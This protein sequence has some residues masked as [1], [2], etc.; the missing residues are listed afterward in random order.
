MKRII[1]AIAFVMATS[2]VLSADD[3]PVTFSQL[4][5]AAQNFINANFPGEKVSF[6]TKDDDVIRPEYQVVLSNGM[7]LQ[8][9]NN[10][11]ME[12]IQTRDG[13][14]P[15]SLIPVQIREMV[16]M[17]YPDAQIKEYEVGRRTYEVKLS[18]RM[19]LKFNRNFHVIEIDD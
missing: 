7:M 5:Q 12:K 3:R 2:S 18:N 6:A 14:I 19:E 16:K 15:E 17:H 8:F 4:P 9:E 10:G 11:S 13:N 1:I